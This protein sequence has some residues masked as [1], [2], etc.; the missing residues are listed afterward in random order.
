MFTQLRNRWFQPKQPTL[1][2]SKPPN[3][4]ENLIELR[5]VIKSYE[6]PVGL[7]VAL[8]NANLTVKAG[9]FVAVIGKSGSGKSTLINMITGIDRP[10]L[11]EIYVAGKPVHQLDEGEMAVWRGHHLG[12]IFQF[13]QLLPTLTLLENVILPMEFARLY[14]APERKARALELLRMVDVA[15]HANKYPTAVSGGQQQR[16]AIARALANDPDVLV[17][18]EPTGNLDAK[19]ADA[20]FQIFEDFARQGRTILMVT[21]DNELASRASRVVLLADG[22]IAEASVSHALPALDQKQMVELSTRLDPLRYSPG[23]VIFRQGDPADKF[24][25][26]IK[27]EVEVVL[28]HPSGEEVISGTMGQ[29]QYFGE[30]GLLKDQ[31][32]T[33]TIRVAQ[34]GEVM[35]M[36]LDRAMFQQ[37]MIDSEVTHREIALMM[38]QRVTVNQLMRIL[39]AQTSTKLIQPSDYA[40]RTFQPGE[41]IFQKGDVAGHF[42]LIYSGAVEIM[43]PGQEETVLMRLESGQH[44]GEQGLEL[45]AGKRTQTIRAAADLEIPTQLISIEL[46]KFNQLI[47]DNHLVAD[48]IALTLH[49]QVAEKLE[50]R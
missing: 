6:T 48:E 44:F 8:K 45:T 16:V 9:E 49:Q 46:E 33:A 19:T 1:L 14:N 22:E 20:I 28:E 37:L 43:M 12:I 30:V 32:R 36:A 39:S 47:R 29:G 31:P 40:L 35:L 24:Y 3:Q 23:T 25:I 18:D 27:G 42:Y 34:T 50:E 2:A 11:G 7:F 10:T 5:N 41:L 4:R 26:I 15:D 21:H 13:F 17:A 38:R